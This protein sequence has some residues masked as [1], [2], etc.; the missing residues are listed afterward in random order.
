MSEISLTT[1]MCVAPDA[2]ERASR[3]QFAVNLLRMN[4]TEKE[5]RARIQRH[6][7]CS[8]WT[9]SRTVDMARD[10]V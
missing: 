2:V 1:L 8:R 6:Y 4:A 10:V 5:V 9:A 3:L 7:N